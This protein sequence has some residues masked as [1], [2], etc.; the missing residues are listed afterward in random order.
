DILIAR[1]AWRQYRTLVE[2]DDFPA[3]LVAAMTEQE[4]ADF[5]ATISLSDDAA[6]PDF[7]ELLLAD[8]VAVLDRKRKERDKEA[9]DLAAKEEA[10]ARKNLLWAEEEALRKTQITQHEL[11]EAVRLLDGV[12]DYINS[13]RK[14]VDSITAHCEAVKQRL[15]RP[16]PVEKGPLSLKSG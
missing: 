16:M 5:Q 11:R 15:L 2:A 12:D 13:C 1:L 14:S 10:L 4:G 9:T 8:A 7:E 6:Q 3:D